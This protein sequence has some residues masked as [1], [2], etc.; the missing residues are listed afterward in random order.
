M[1]NYVLKKCLQW[2]SIA[3]SKDPFFSNPSDYKILRN[4]WPYGVD[5]D[6]THLVVWTKFRMDS[7]TDDTSS[8]HRAAIENFVCKTFCD[9]DCGGLT[10]C[11]VTWFKNWAS[12]RSIDGIEHFHVMLYQAS[13]DFIDRICIT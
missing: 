1:L 2:P 13:E 9:V 11:S 12:L 3:P 7:T 10:R 4:D 8:P 6:I 5:I